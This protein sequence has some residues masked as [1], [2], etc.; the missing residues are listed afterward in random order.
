M[1]KTTTSDKKNIVKEQ[2]A[3]KS[4][5]AF[6]K[7]NYIL[8]LIAFGIILIGYA[9]MSGG[10]AENPSVFNEEIFSFRRITLAP[11]VVIIGYIVGVYAILKKAD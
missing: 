4:E 3:D 2:T 10:K 11:V 8:F 5:F 1:A 6:G 9:L 7:E